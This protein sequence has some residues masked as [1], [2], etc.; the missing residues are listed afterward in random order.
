M[1]MKLCIEQYVL[2]LYKVYKNDDPEL[3]LT[4]VKTKSNLVK[5]V[6]VLT[7]GPDIRLAFTGPMV[8]WFVVV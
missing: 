2:K 7:V 8:L 3:T 5:L 4:H 1:I 6:F